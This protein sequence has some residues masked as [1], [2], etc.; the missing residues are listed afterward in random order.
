METFETFMKQRIFQDRS[1]L[2][3]FNYPREF[4]YAT[5]CSDEISQGRTC[6]QGCIQLTHYQVQGP[7]QHI[8]QAYKPSPCSPQTAPSQCP[9]QHGYQSWSPLPGH[10]ALRLLIELAMCF[11]EF[12]LQSKSLPIQHSSPLLFHR[13]QMCVVF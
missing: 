11:S 12:Q 2:Q 13:C 9:N 3:L 1:K 6:F 4:H 5:A 8:N 7:T 10:L